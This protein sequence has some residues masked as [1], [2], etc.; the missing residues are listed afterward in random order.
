MSLSA[1]EIRRHHRALADRLTAL[2][3]DD[4]DVPD[5]AALVRFLREELLP[6]AEEEERVLYDRIEPLIPSGQATLTMRLDHEAIARLT[7]ELAVLTA[8]A[9]GAS[10]GERPAIER[11]LARRAADL[12]AIVRLHLEK[13]ERAYLPLYERSAAERELDV[14][15]VPPPRRHP[16]IFQTFEAL[17]PGEAFVL[18]NDHDPKPLFYQFQAELTGRFTWDYLER[19]PHVWRVRIGKVG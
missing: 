2:V 1:E 7:D 10:P 15:A 14:R 13:E 11:R 19:G 8:A 4:G 17:A 9:A 3:P 12:V 5:P 18:V 6:H 16:L